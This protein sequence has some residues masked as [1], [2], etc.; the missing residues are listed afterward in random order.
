MVALVLSFVLQLNSVLGVVDEFFG[1][2]P[3]VKSLYAKKKGISPNGWDALEREWYSMIR[4]GF[5]SY[6]AH[7]RDRCKNGGYSII[8]T[9]HPKLKRYYFQ[10]LV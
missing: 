2:A 4:V 7:M 6:C 8:T 9:C 3:E 10:V 1:L 5:I